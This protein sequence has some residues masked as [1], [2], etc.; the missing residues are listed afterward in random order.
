MIRIDEKHRGKK[1]RCKTCGEGLLVPP[2]T[3]EA[4]EFVAD[5]LS[6]SYN[7]EEASQER[8]DKAAANTR[9]L[10]RNAPTRVVDEKKKVTAGGVAGCLGLIL[11]SASVLIYFGSGSRRD[12]VQ[13]DSSPEMQAKREQMI[14]DLKQM[15]IIQKIDMPGSLPHVWVAPAFYALQY[16]QKSTFISV[17][18][19]YFVA[20]NPSL[21]PTVLYDGQTGK[22]VGLFSVRTG[23]KLY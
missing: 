23:L 13:I 8:Q 18:A 10:Q 22:K 16:D 17:V 7:T 5:C 11:I 9:Q 3:E 4:D 19:A 2:A 20:K 21:D 12:S 6:D 14:E 15:R 1:G